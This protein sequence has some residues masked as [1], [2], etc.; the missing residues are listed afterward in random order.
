MR[1][2]WE[3]A[4]AG[5]LAL[6]VVLAAAP[7]GALAAEW[8]W[9]PTLDFW[10]DHDTNRNLV[11]QAIPSEGTAMALDMRLRYATERLTLALDPQAVLQRFSDREFG[12]SND[13]RVDGKLN[14]LTER[15]AVALTS[16]LSDQTLL[17]TELATTG[18]IQPGIRRRDEDATASWT[19]AQSA[20]RSLTVQASYADTSY[21][22]ARLELTALRSN[23]D[24]TL[25]A[26]EQIQYS[27]RIATLVTV[28]A[29]NFQAQA[30][31]GPA[32]TIG[33]TTGFKAQLAERTT[34]NADAGL[35][36]NTLLSTVVQGFAGDLTLTRATDTG[37]YSLSASRS[38][39]PIG[40][41]E[42]TQSDVLK[43]GVVRDLAP[44]LSFNSSL[45]VTR[46]TSVFRFQSLRIDLTY[47]DRTY[48]QLAMGLVWR[49]SE[50]WSVAA[51]AS[52]NRAEGKTV[53]N[54]HGW[55]ARLEAQ[56]TPVP[57]SASR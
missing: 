27:D 38:V 9:V 54:A 6:A 55:Q 33:V 13:A 7:V 5:Q 17:S 57:H 26:S 49:T 51:R 18:I 24:T 53:P 10:I 50:T 8:S 39:A 12:N 29:S 22:G 14:W 52:G 45:G 36:R 42:I 3:S 43:V 35:D 47:L 1:R 16:A 15:S 28:S 46:N 30:E 31:S 37:N 34:L 48:T 19:Y 56:W 41:G 40:L 25:A 11:P 21:R 32:R 2:P 20:T 23:R 4:P 44:Q